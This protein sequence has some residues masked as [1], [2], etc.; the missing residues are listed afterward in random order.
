MSKIFKFCAVVIS[1]VFLLSGT[2]L[3]EHVDKD[4]FFDIGI[5]VA[6]STDLTVTVLDI[7]DGAITTDGINFLTDDATLDNPWVKSKERLNIGYSSNYGTWGLRIM[8]DNITYLGLLTTLQFTDPTAVGYLAGERYL[9]TTM[10]G[11]N[12]PV[13]AGYY[14]RFAGM[15]RKDVTPLQWK[16]PNLVS[17][18][19][20][21]PMADPLPVTQYPTI[22]DCDTVA[23]PAPHTG[24]IFED[25]GIETEIG[26]GE[27]WAYVA[28]KISY[29]DTSQVPGTP[30][31]PDPTTP[32]FDGR[33]YQGTVGGLNVFN[34]NLIAFGT[35]VGGGYM[36]VPE[37]AGD[38]DIAVYLTARF[39]YTDWGETPNSQCN[40]YTLGAGSYGT[41]LIVE[42]V[43][44]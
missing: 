20:W 12:D 7:A 29:K 28:D 26:Q 19:G 34:Y 40:V 27:L 36:Q 16:N 30:G 39:G 22:P 2:I 44:E 38:G 25:V 1:A 8:T 4:W 37:V 18:L 17:I 6:G 5:N 32:Y 35:G 14:Y 41:R 9:E 31:N 21:Q 15:H 11:L 3:A 24:L 33:V 10:G 13:P 23:A 43:N 42:L